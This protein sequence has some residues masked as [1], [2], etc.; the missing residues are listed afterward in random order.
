MMGWILA[1]IT[2][3]TILAVLFIWITGGHEDGDH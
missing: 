1:A 3:G 2:L